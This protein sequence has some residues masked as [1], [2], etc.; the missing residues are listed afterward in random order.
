MRLTVSLRLAVA[1]AFLAGS[2]FAQDARPPAAATLP[3]ADVHFHLMTF[4]TPADLKARMEK[5]NIQ[6]T[7]SA[8]AFG[9]P[10]VATPME[11]DAG[12]QQLLK[13]RYIPATGLYETYHAER[14]VGVRLYTDQ[15]SPEREELLR[16]I[17]EQLAVQ[18]RVVAEMVPN[19]ESSS[20][21]PTFRRRIATDGPYYR[22]LLTVAKKQGRPVPMH[23]QFHRESVQQLSQLL[24]DQPDGIVLLSHCGKDSAAKDVRVM[25]EKHPNL[26]C[27]LS[28]RGAPLATAESRQDP[29]RLIFWG[30]SLFQSAGMKPEWRQLVEDHPDR[31]MVGIDD[32]HSWGIYD[33]TVTAIREGVLAQLTPATAEKVAFRNAVRLFRLAAPDA[34]VAGAE[35]AAQ[36]R[37][38]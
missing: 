7:I 8:G 20:V 24:Q 19:A 18:P 10:D 16:S 9:I 21:L 27:D 13:D 12:A 36:Q 25:L 11:R 6:W 26:Y 14:K 15:P 5:H 22:Q 4:M 2:V 28:F 38:P 3:L 34:A 29:A 32:V 37:A 30:K 17:E 35:P 31:F 33:D 1:T 23:M